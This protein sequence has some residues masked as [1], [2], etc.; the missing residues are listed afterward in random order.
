MKIPSDG[1]KDKESVPQNQENSKH[2]FAAG[3]GG[4]FTRTAF[5]DTMG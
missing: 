5:A 2:N 4:T 1:L 3:P